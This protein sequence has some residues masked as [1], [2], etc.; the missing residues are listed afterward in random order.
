M[1]V[2]ETLYYYRLRGLEDVQETAEVSRENETVLKNYL[3]LCR[4][5]P[6]RESVRTLTGLG[7][8][9]RGIPGGLSLQPPAGPALT[10]AES[11]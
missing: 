7:A 5:R 2:P 8:F 4:N 1:F 10:R 11:S 9:L 3:F 6:V